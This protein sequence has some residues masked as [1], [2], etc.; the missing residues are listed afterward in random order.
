MEAV[1][2]IRKTD[3]ARN[4]REVLNTVMRGQTALIE[5]HGKAEAAII[6]IVDYLILRAVMRYHARPPQIAVD[7]GL[8]DAAAEATPNLQARYN[9]VLTHYLADAISLSRAAELLSLPS[10]DLRLRFVRLDVP[11]RLGPA[12]IEEALAEVETL[13]Q[14]RD[15][16][17][18]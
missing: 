14:L 2:R 8:T 17:A 10:F 13:R 11:L 6:D 12:T 7:A 1:Q 3:L 4:T 16:Q 18:V 9:L 5:S 15:G